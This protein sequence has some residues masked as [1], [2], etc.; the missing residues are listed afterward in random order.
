MTTTSA[1]IPT[2]TVEYGF[3]IKHRPGH[4]NGTQARADSLTG[5]EWWPT[6]RQAKAAARRSTTLY[7]PAPYVIIQRW[8]SDAQEVPAE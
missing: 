2:L 7:T 5:K 3:G 1:S 6:V 4:D 8:V